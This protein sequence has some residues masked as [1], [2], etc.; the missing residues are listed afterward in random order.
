MSYSQALRVCQS[1]KANW[2]LLCHAVLYRIAQDIGVYALDAITLDKV[3]P[4]GSI[5]FFEVNRT[6]FAGGWFH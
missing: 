4:H 2:E 5:W 6:G 1:L 3:G